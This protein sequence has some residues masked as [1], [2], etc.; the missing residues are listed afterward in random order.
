MCDL[1]GADDRAAKRDVKLVDWPSRVRLL[2]YIARTVV[3]QE[4]TK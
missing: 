2:G 1:F 3:P 4:G